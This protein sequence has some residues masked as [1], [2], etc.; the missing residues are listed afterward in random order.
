MLE[1]AH[2]ITTKSCEHIPENKR[3]STIPSAQHWDNCEGL[4]VLN[5]RNRIEN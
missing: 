2:L 1:T 3:V 4:I 5:L